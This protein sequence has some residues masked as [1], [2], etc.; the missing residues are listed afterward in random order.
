VDLARRRLGLIH[1]TRFTDGLERLS[2]LCQTGIALRVVGEFSQ[3]LPHLREA[4]RLAAEARD[5]SQLVTAL[6]LQAQC[7]FGLDCWEEML[8]I[9]TRQKMIVAEYGS[10]RVDRMCMYCGI[11]ANVLGWMGELEAARARRQEAYDR[12]VE[13]WLGPPNTWPAVG[14]Y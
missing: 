1:D 3:A 14:H 6:E 9:D 13:Y 5:V 4:E 7:L 10:D 2:V 8:Q 12:M 11:S